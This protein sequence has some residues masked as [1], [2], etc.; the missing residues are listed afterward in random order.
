[1]FVKTLSIAVVP[2]PAYVL[3]AV[4]KSGV[5]YGDI[6]CNP[7]SALHQPPVY[8]YVPSPALLSPIT[9]TS[10][11]STPFL[12]SFKNLDES[13]EYSIYNGVAKRAEDK[14]EELNYSSSLDNHI[15]GCTSSTN[16]DF[17]DNNFIQRNIPY[18]ASNYNNL[19]NLKMLV[20]NNNHDNI[21]VLFTNYS[22]LAFL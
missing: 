16:C 4:G 19:N 17:A 6:P 14:K 18:T 13:G 11:L 21:L 9:T 8:P 22:I 3:P 20:N 12:R 15:Q 1:M 2:C 5:A 7:P 10:R